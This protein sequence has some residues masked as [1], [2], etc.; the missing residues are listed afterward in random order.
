MS[1]FWRIANGKNKT[2]SSRV[3]VQSPIRRVR[4]FLPKGNFSE[5]V[6]SMETFLL[7]V[8]APVY[9]FAVM[10]HLA[11]GDLEFVQEDI[12]ECSRRFEHWSSYSCR[13]TRPLE[14][15]ERQDNVMYL[16]LIL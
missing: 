4:H 13:H 16:S 1:Q 3:G 15:C 9:L 12:Q 14:G 6:N 7:F 11:A 2:H 10:E 5:H 8:R